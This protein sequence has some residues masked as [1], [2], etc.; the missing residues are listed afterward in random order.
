M[1]K[2]L[3]IAMLALAVSACSTVSYH[4]PV[5]EVARA[6][7]VSHQELEKIAPKA[8]AEAKRAFLDLYHRSPTARESLRM[9]PKGCTRRAARAGKNCYALMDLPGGNG[10]TIRAGNDLS[11]AVQITRQVA[12]YT[13]WLKKIAA[14]DNCVAAGR[15]AEAAFAQSVK[16]YEIA[17]QKDFP[18]TVKVAAL[19]LRF[20][21]CLYL[22]RRKLNA[23][24]QTTS[25]A[26]GAVQLASNHLV[27]MLQ[28]RAFSSVALARAELS[29]LESEMLPGNEAGPQ[30]QAAALYIEKVAAL[31]RALKYAAGLSALAEGMGPAHQALVKA[32][33]SAE[34]DFG[35]TYQAAQNLRTGMALL[36]RAFELETSE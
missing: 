9:S 5:M 36:R 4:Q 24:R 16:L 25:L 3:S 21:V 28:A 13:L 17:G 23:L 2:A 20:G 14:A 19:P 22:E 1:R 29:Q 8:D 31:N 6:M 32:V 30:E 7:R 35:Q 27:E 33:H 12:L 11:H 15:A 26:D 34:P 10:L 18:G